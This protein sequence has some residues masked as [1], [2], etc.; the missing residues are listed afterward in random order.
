MYYFCKDFQKNVSNET[1][2]ILSHSVYLNL[3]NKKR[4]LNYIYIK[5]KNFTIVL[6]WPG[7]VSNLAILSEYENTLK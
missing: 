1:Q 7:S 6:E 2:F 4:V 5:M 3:E